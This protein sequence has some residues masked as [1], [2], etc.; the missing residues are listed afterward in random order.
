[1]NHL[2]YNIELETSTEERNKIISLLEEQ[3][4]IVNEIS[5]IVTEN[6]LPKLS[7]KLI[8]DKCYYAI[9][10]KFPTAFSQTIVKAEQEVLANLRSIRSN[11]HKKSQQIEKKNLSLRLDKRLYSNL[12]QSS[13]RLSIWKNKKTEVKFKLYNKVIDLF[14]RGVACDPLMFVRNNRVFLSMTFELATPTPKDESRLGVDLGMR[15][16]YTTSDGNCL[17]GTEY[18]KH[19]RRIRYNKRMAQQT[20]TKSGKRK[21]RKLKRKEANF[22][23]NYIHH[24]ANKLLKTN[25]SVIVM[26]D[27]SKIKTKKHK[28]QNLNAKSQIPFYMLKSILTYKATLVGKQVVSVNP[29]FTSQDDCRGLKRGTRKGCRYYG[30][31]GVIMDADWNASNNIAKRYCPEHPISF[32]PLDGGLNLIGRLLSTSQKSETLVSDKPTGLQP[33]GS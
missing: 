24:V 32:I 21:L 18:L 22:S 19:K 16:L 7:I 8:H 10:N 5:A 28:Y 1:M 20:K 2:T 4:S 12:T 27:L 9:K 15:R 25:K 23:K 11:K 29:A 26:E 3:R 33:V 6:K 17:K 13:I 14:N 31:D 30:V